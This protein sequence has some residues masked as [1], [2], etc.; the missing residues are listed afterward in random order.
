ME[1]GLGKLKKGLEVVKTDSVSTVL[2]LGSLKAQVVDLSSQ[3][4][5][6]REGLKV[7]TNTRASR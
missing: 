2:E 4:V 1:N 7:E 5:M 3:T 6:M